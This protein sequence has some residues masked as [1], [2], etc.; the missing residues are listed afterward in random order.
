MWSGCM[1]L[2]VQT[3]RGRWGSQSE[4]SC[5]LYW[6]AADDH[7]AMSNKEIN[8]TTLHRWQHWATME[9]VSLLAGCMQLSSLQN[10]KIVSAMPM[11]NAITCTYAA[12]KTSRLRYPARHIRA[13]CRWHRRCSSKDSQ[14]KGLCFTRGYTWTGHS[15]KDLVRRECLDQPTILT[16]LERGSH[17]AS[18]SGLCISDPKGRHLLC[19]WMHHFG[20]NPCHFLLCV[21]I[22]GLL[23]DRTSAAAHLI[24][25][26]Q[27]WG[28]PGFKVCGIKCKVICS[29][30][31]HNDLQWQT[32]RVP[33]MYLLWIALHCMQENIQ[34]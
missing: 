3:P 29:T 1:K 8:S 18:H 4:E 2:L 28:L 22:S 30:S 6:P 24:Y 11:T 31:H 34:H 21:E 12:C 16:E 20:T 7:K 33:S 15:N 19:E 25:K 17:T 13:S 5:K 23:S 14:M 10:I 32:E 26:L 9:R 27:V